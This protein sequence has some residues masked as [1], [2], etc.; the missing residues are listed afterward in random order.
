MLEAALP[1]LSQ[2]PDGFMVVAEEEAT[3]NLG[4]DNNSRGIVEANLRADATLGVAMDFIRN[5]NP[6]TL[7]VTAA[8]SEAGGVQVWQPTPFGPALPDVIDTVAGLP[9]NPTDTETFQNPVDGAEGRLF[10]LDTFAAEPSLDGEMGNFVTA[11]AGT[12]DFSGNIVAKSYGLNADLLPSTLDNTFIYEMMYRTLFGDEAFD[13][14][15]GEII[16]LTGIDGDVVLDVTVGRE[17]GFDNVLRFYETD[18]QGRVGGLRPGQA[19]YEEVVAANLL[20]AE[21]F[22]ANNTMSELVL[23]LAG[24]TYYAP[25]LLIDGSLSD[26]ATIEDRVLG[27]SRIQREGNVWGFEDLTDNDFNDLVVTFNSVEPAVV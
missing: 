13:V 14:P 3:D 7:L 20:D 25:A 26:L 18:A 19:G 12:S 15:F 8:D 2:D 9:V 4:N 5:E 21:L 24:G 11:W 27:S 23:S 6:N 22:T 17:A 1:I 10:P 16:D